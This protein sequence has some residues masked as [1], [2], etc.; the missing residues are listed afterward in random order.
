M[1]H[2]GSRNTDTDGTSR[3]L[4]VSTDAHAG[5]S[6]VKDLR[7]Y[8]PRRYLD[9]YDAFIAAS[10][11]P[12]D[13]IG[14]LRA[15]LQ[16]EY[17]Q[18][19]QLE[20]LRRT[21]ECPGQADMAAR[22]SDMDADGVAAE[23]IFA[24]GQNEEGLPFIG[25]GSDA[26]S[27]S[28][29]A[30]LRA[31][32]AHIWNAWL[33]DFVS[34]DP[35]RHIGVMQVP[36]WDADAA[37]R[38]VRWGYHTGLR[39]VNFPAPREDFPAYTSEV[40]EPFWA[41]CEELRLPL[42]T[43]A[44]GG[45]PGLAT[46]GPGGKY[47]HR[48]E[49]HWLGRRGLWQLLFGGVFERHPGLKL[50]FTEQRVG[51]VPETLRELDSIHED[52]VWQGWADDEKSV[53]P[54]QYW[55][56]NCFVAA[57]FIAPFEVRLHPVVGTGNLMWGSDYPHPEGT[58]P[59]TRLALRNAFAGVP[60]SVVRKVLGENALR[61]YDLDESALRLVAD[62]IGPKPAELDQPLEPQEFPAFRGLAFRERGAYT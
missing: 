42:V 47:I 46:D 41:I 22:V 2:S 57:S 14:R 23:V 40:Y 24:G 58:W 34:L 38:E 59:S 35:H 8:C 19:L 16:S 55:E 39:A 50:V 44:G 62:R 20:A 49:L 37:V 43:H 4:I 7:P 33:A 61:V 3:Y 18:H 13:D 1:S 9:D 17:S 51:W 60:E 56:Q 29:S 6:V 53:R 28:W 12:D 31:V 52:A 54:S 15:S 27:T 32:G 36:I 11:Q 25:F 26:G 48:A 5:P 30:E 10:V 21:K 45:G